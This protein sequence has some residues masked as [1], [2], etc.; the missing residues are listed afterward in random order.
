MGFSRYRVSRWLKL[1]FL[2]TG[3]LALLSLVPG[4]WASPSA[5]GLRQ[6]VPSRTPTKEATNTPE[7]P[8][9]TPVPDTAT[10]APPTKTP[11]PPT[12]TLQSGTP[13]PSPEKTT[14]SA[15]PRP[16]S[17]SAS[18]TPPA[19]TGTLEAPAETPG[20]TDT[21]VPPVSGPELLGTAPGPQLG[22]PSHLGQGESH[23]TIEAASI[24]SLAPRARPIIAPSSQAQDEAEE[25]ALGPYL[26]AGLALLLLG[27]VVYVV[28]GRRGASLDL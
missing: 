7:S 22:A 12:A 13:Y 20:P 14:P 6:T 28:T 19:A 27:G 11:V 5:V 17:T 26:A 21:P 1:G 16:T 4:A 25:S 23:R 9:N 10:P 3:V 8:T 15:T 24:P 2:V 18:P